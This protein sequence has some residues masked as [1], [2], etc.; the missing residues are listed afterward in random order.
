MIGLTVNIIDEFK[1]V[2]NAAAAA[3]FKNLNHAAATIRKTAIE[4]IE[5]AEGPSPP[6]SPPHT[7]TTSKTKSGKTRAGVLPRSIAYDVNQDSA[8]IGPRFSVVG[9]AGAAMEHGGEFRGDDYDARPFMF[10]AL[11]SNESR[12][13]EEWQGAIGE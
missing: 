6:G 2:E 5:S 13:A 11:E 8:V 3:T 9:E 12:F 10:P 4:S 7:H 1:R